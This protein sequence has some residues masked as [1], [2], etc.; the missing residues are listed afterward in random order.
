MCA[1]NMYAESGAFAFRAVARLP[2][3]SDFFVSHKTKN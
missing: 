2:L 3:A 1:G